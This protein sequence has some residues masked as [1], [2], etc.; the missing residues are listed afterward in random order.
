[1][2]S[3]TAAGLGIILAF[4]GVAA[5]RAA[6]PAGV[7]R[8]D[9]IAVDLRVLAVA[10]T[11]GLAAG[12]FF[13]V[14]PAWSAARS[15]P[16]SLLASGTARVTPGHRRWRTSFLVGEIVLVGAL[17]VVSTLF[18]GSFVHVLR[19]DLGFIREGLVAVTLDEMRGFT[20]PTE[21][22][23]HALR[24]TPGVVAVAEWTGPPSFLA[25]GGAFFY[26]SLKAAEH[27]NDPGE[28]SVL[29]HGISPGFFDTAG[30]RLLRGR[31]FTDADIDA[32]V[33]II[34]ELTAG[35]LF[36]DG[37]DPLGSVVLFGSTPATPLTVVGVVQTVRR[38][39]PERLAGPQL[40]RPKPVVAPRGSQFLVRTS[41][42]ASTAVPAIQRSLRRMLPP[43]T[44][45]PQVRSIEH[46]FDELTTGRRANAT[47]MSL[48]GVIV[49]L[50]GSAGVYAVMASTVAQQQR[51]LGVRVAL[52]A[53]RARIIRSVLGRATLY[54]AIG[55][56][57][58]LA[59][60]RALSTVFA[61]MLFEVRP[62]DASTYAIVAALL[63][64]TGLAAALWP[65]LR[66]ARV[67][68]I[69]TLRA[70]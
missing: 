42:S 44:V 26:H 19:M 69:T 53:T 4:W 15:R 18:V 1:M 22:V 55:L 57:V 67:D 12:I 39:G 5:A 16:V 68:P 41:G 38:D 31:A 28:I 60:G 23:V 24:T 47:I 11:T 49:L 33:A 7:F 61:S 2:L 37:R 25:R 36:F 52:G 66:A 6:L 21:P 27:A 43:D 40:Y 3:L 9:T 29:T 17:L 10:V 13:G 48:F 32:P 70:E 50:I 56:A 30:I 8:A 58:G 14:V 46:D 63:M 54:L 62:G 45:E 51:E 59:A 20:G 65:A 64:T 35:A 34:D